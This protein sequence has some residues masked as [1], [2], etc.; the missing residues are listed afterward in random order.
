MNRLIFC[1][2]ITLVEA[3]GSWALAGSDGTWKVG[4]S[5]SFLWSDTANWVNDTIAEGQDA[6]GY[7]DTADPAYTH[8]SLNGASRTIGHLIFNDTVLGEKDFWDL[9]TGSLILSVSS[10]TPT[11]EVSDIGAGVG[12]ASTL[13]VSGDFRKTGNQC[14]YLKRLPNSSIDIADGMLAFADINE[15]NTT[16]TTQSISGSGDV[17]FY[18]QA[19]GYYTFR[20]HEYSGALSYTG[21]TRIR[22]D[23]GGQ[24]FC[25][26][27]WLEKDDLLPHA[28][29]VDLE[30]GKIY[31][32]EQTGNGLTI[33]GLNGNAGTYITTDRDASNIQKWTLDVA[34]GVSCAYAGSIGS[35]GTGVGNG[36]ISL[37][38]KGLGT[39]VL[40]GAN[41]FTGPLVVSEGT[42][43]VDNA[44]GS[45]S[46]VNNALT[47]RS[48]TTL[49][50][51]GTILSASATLEAGCVLIPGGTHAA[52]TLA[53]SN[54]VMASG[55]VYQW[56]SGLLTNDLVR[57]LD[58]VSLP[59]VATVTVSRVGSPLPIQGVL[60]TYGAAN[61]GAADLSAWVVEGPGIV[62]GSCAYDAANRRVLV[63][64]TY[65]GV[66]GTDGVWNKAGGLPTLYLWSDPAN[67]TGG[68]V[69]DGIN[70]IAHFDAVDVATQ[71]ISLG[72]GSR[73]IGHLGFSDTV[74]NSS[75][76]WMLCQGTLDMQVSSGTP[77]ID[78]GNGTVYMEADL[79]MTRDFTKKGTG[80]LWMNNLPAISIEIAEG[81]LAFNRNADGTLFTTQTIFGGGDLAFTG[82]SDG[83]F[84]FRSDYAGTL[85]YT[86]HT[87]VSLAPGT[88]WWRGT[89]WLEKDDVLPHATVVDIRSGKVYVRE[90]TRNGLTVAGVMGEAG[91]AITTDHPWMQKWTVDVANGQSYSY[92]GVIG[93]DGTG[94]GNNNLSLTKSGPGT[95]VLS[96]ANSYSGATTI[97]AGRLLVD[98][99]LSADSAV[100]VSADSTLGG[101]GTVGGNVTVNGGGILA[102]GGMTGVGALTCGGTVSLASGVVYEADSTGTDSDTVVVGGT[103]DLPATL[104][105]KLSATGVRLPKQITL[106][107][108]GALAGAT[109]LGGWQVVG[110]GDRRYELLIDGSRVVANLVPDGTLV[111]IQ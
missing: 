103:L 63:N 99:S 105:V 16:F 20:N 34:E 40:S 88:S 12:F 56:E 81:R 28:T 80:T 39:Q 73:T 49:G 24:W 47:M 54:L 74:P 85:A 111:R 1:A 65:A 52:G 11:V 91:T 89:L 25:G 31:T 62:G 94:V 60:L 102:P 72:Y 38:K 58:T 41:T 87:I 14:L 51:S 108:A 107:T 29:T 66:S 18:G 23:A 9:N 46:G 3:C 106:F 2:V 101:S 76:W 75:D 43:L 95:Q 97:N 21:H 5:G 96:G 92:A 19:N 4:G 7:F 83:Y 30:S 98:G 86:G 55:V 61:T 26:A 37:T 15:E 13:T 71:W 33:A 93:A 67:W 82:Q 8:I 109:D 69:A 10:G 100:T 68:T 104:T 22:L 27:L 77:M 90:Q 59:G 84:S 17:V 45:A 36:N 42:L 32:R 35:D 64:I 70:G 50:G 78:V 6:V 57:V 53:V 110:I 44:G 48:G 79:T